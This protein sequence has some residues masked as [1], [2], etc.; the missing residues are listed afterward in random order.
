MNDEVPVLSAA[1]YEVNVTEDT[2]TGT[3]LLGVSAT[4]LDI[5]EN[6]EL[7]FSVAGGVVSVDGESGEV[8]LVRELDHEEASTLEIEV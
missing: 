3:S 1:R 2:E 5:G 7:T 6:A 4:D 8:E